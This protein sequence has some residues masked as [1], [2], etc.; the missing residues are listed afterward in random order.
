MLSTIAHDCRCN[1]LN[2]STLIT[3]LEKLDRKTY[4]YSLDI[5]GL[6]NEIIDAVY[7]HIKKRQVGY[8]VEMINRFNSLVSYLR[9]SG[10]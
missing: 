6:F 7:E 4:F 5:H 2:V 10:E 1:G 9:L 8:Q 3:L